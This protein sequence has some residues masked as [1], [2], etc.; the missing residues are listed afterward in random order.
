MKNLGTIVGAL[1]G[2]AAGF[3]AAK[4]YSSILSATLGVAAYPFYPL[5]MGTGAL[6]LGYVGKKLYQSNK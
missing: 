5:M 2:G 1:M 3:L 6:A 4:K